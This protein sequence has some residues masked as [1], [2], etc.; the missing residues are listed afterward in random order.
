MAS[1]VETATLRV[2]DQSSAQLRKINAELKKLQATANSLKTISINLRINTGQLQAALRQLNSLAHNMSQLRQHQLSLN[3][4]TAGIQRAQQQVA[5]LRRAASRPITVPTVSGGAGGAGRGAGTGGVHGRGARVP[6]GGTTIP[7]GPLSALRG[8]ASVVVGGTAYAIGASIMRGVLDGVHEVDAGYTSLQLKQLDR[9]YGKGAY[10]VAEGMLTSAQFKA[11]QMP[12]GA[13]WNLGQRARNFSEAL[14][15]TQAQ[16]M[17]D[18]DAQGRPRRGRPSGE[19]EYKPAL[20][21]V[22]QL[23]ETS[24]MLVGLGQSSEKAEEQAMNFA[25]GLEQTGR[26]TDRLTGAF[27]PK[28]MEDSFNFIRQL[29][30]TIGKEFTGDFARTMIK[31]LS[32]EKYTVSDRALGAVMLMG[33]EYGSRA[34]V[35]YHQ[36]VKQLSGQGQ[37]KGQLQFMFEEGLIGVAGWKTIGKGKR[38]RKA[39]IWGEAIDQ[40]LLREDLPQWIDKHLVPILEKR[41][42]AEGKKKV[43]TGEI[44]ATQLDQFVEKYKTDPK[45]ISEL[46]YKVVG[47]RTAIET[48]AGFLERSQEIQRQLNEAAQRSGR[49]EDIREATKFSINIATAQLQNQFKGMA[50]T[51]AREAAPWLVPQMQRGAQEMSAISTEFK[52]QLAKGQVPLNAMERISN[53]LTPAAI[54]GAV[55]MAVADPTKAPMAIATIALTTAGNLLIKAANKFL[56]RPEGEG[57]QPFGVPP[58]TPEGVRSQMI[59]KQIRQVEDD[60]KKAQKGPEKEDPRLRQAKEIIDYNQK[61]IDQGKQLSPGA[62]KSF[63]A[64]KK[65]LSENA[66]KPQ[67]QLNEENASKIRALQ[68]QI[69]DLKRD[70][71]VAV[72]EEITGQKFDKKMQE[73]TEARRLEAEEAKAVADYVKKLTPA[74]RKKFWKEREPDLRPRMVPDELGGPKV[75]VPTRAPMPKPRPPDII[76]RV[77]TPGP[78]EFETPGPLLLPPGAAPPTVPGAPGAGGL[79]EAD[80]GTARSAFASI[81]GTGKTTIE[82]AGTTAASTFVSDS[83]AGAGR[84][85]S[86]AASAFLAQVSGATINVN[87]NV[88]PTV[89]AKADAGAQ[90]A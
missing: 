7:H 68:A 14:G 17:A 61:I 62:Q 26:F 50:G 70:L 18:L 56:G 4:N 76:N 66:Y 1:F 55:A 22:K 86:V 74:Q 41:G 53:A 11:G 58:D 40:D 3:V 9:V 63:D 23:E 64:A 16:N 29:M 84:I 47:D 49:P 60:L 43:E 35:G 46:A 19:P 5:A 2:N 33:E 75:K 44:T 77:E 30:P 37:K 45:K 32:T 8:A 67:Q 73:F 15:I 27:D 10:Q 81:F 36:A 48:V 57:T 21:I 87:A 79:T 90:V 42:R 78:I 28:K 24:R 31:Y 88:T 89:T 82:G 52:D 80:F 51:M 65:L 71:A 25:K 54:A 72:G 69:F 38:A 34:A 85:G 12:G 39:P 83:A 59:Q 13:F 20:A 6:G